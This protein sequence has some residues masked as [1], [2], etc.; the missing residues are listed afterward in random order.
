[1]NVIWA[2]KNA[3]GLLKL[4]PWFEYR[5]PVVFARIRVVAGVWLLILTAILYGYGRGGW[6]AVLLIPA[7]TAD[8][9]LAHLLY[10]LP[11]AANASPG[12][13]LIDAE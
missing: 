6:W 7:G 3:T 4:V 12:D 1:M 8:F 11:G 2:D 10:R 9:Y 5:H 13:A